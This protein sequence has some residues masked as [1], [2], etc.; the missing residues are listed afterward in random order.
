VHAEA[1]TREVLEETLSQMEV[2]AEEV[3][4]PTYHANHWILPNGILGLN[5]SPITCSR[6]KGKATLRLPMLFRTQGQSKAPHS[7]P[8]RKN[9]CYERFP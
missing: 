6:G 1:F 8:K 7:S 4:A 5:D 2:D 9:D 3:D